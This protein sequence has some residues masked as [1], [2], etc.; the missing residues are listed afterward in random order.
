MQTLCQ[1]P[2]TVARRFEMEL[3]RIKFHT[4]SISQ[5]EEIKMLI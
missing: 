3:A 1:L 5:S 2:H 4:V